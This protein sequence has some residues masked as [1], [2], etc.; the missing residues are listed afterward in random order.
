MTKKLL[1]ST[2]QYLANIG[3]SYI[4]LHNLHWNVTGAQFKAVHEYLEALYDAYADI[5]DEVAEILRMD[6]ELPPASMKEYLEIATIKELPSEEICIK[7]TLHTLLSDMELLKWEAETLRKLA[8]EED[9]Y[10]MANTLEEHLANYTKNIWFLHAML[11]KPQ[12]NDM[13]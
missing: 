11:K 1:K 2:N 13:V 12:R 8:G 5:L 7:D 10:L 6:G 4:K 3:V 9:H